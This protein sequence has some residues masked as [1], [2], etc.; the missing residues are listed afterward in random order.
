MWFRNRWH[1]IA[2][3]D[4]DRRAYGVF[5]FLVAVCTVLGTNPVE[6]KVASVLMLFGLACLSFGKKNPISKEDS[7][8]TRS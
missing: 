6:D 1:F 8:I 5:F 2:T 3:M 4:P 7:G